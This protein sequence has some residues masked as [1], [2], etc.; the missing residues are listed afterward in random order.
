[1]GGFLQ[2]GQAAAAADGGSFGPGRITIHTKT[3]RLEQTHCQN[4]HHH[5]PP[6]HCV[7]AGDKLV[8]T[9]RQ[10]GV[11]LSCLGTVLAQ[12]LSL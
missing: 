3:G 1:M 7:I 5:H 12:K 11:D 8:V 6:H 2:K 9:I 10:S 4:H